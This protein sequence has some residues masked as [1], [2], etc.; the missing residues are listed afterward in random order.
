MQQ[1]HLVDVS[2]L[3]ELALHHHYHIISSEAFTSL[4]MLFINKF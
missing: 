2:A 1:R 4:L 3:F